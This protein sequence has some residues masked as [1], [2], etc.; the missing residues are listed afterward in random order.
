MMK[1]RFT[2]EQIIQILKEQEASGRTGEVCRR[3]GIC[4][5]TFYKWKAKFGGM[6]ASDARRLRELEDE[7]RRLAILLRREGCVV[8]IKKI[9]R[10][11]REEGLAVK[12]RK[13]RKRAIGTRTPL[14]RPDS[15]G[16][17]WSLDFM[18]DALACGRRLRLLGVMD[19]CSRE[20]LA[21]VI[22]TSMPGARVVRELDA[23]IRK[24]GKPQVIVSD[25]GTEL[26]SRAVLQWAAE[27]KIEWHYITPGRPSENGFTES[28]NGKIRDECLNEHWF[29]SLAE[30]RT[31]IEAW[32][33]DYNHVRPHSSLG[34]MTPAEYARK[35]IGGHGPRSVDLILNTNYKT[36]RTLLPAGT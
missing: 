35:Q 16:Q 29:T 2:E 14:P 17:V 8:N 24:Y 19:Q 1:K 20:C 11:Y 7:N 30:A 15:V 4:S 5:A 31:I 3:Y 23:L 6:E 27:R 10:L 33:Q 26:T 9:H 36:E 32:R 13:G 25:N 21:L 12:R 28:L 34:Y 22:D 18:S